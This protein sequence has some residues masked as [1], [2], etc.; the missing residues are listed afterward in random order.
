MHLFLYLSNFFNVR[1]KQ[2]QV[3]AYTGV[4]IS[5]LLFVDIHDLSQLSL[6]WEK[7]SMDPMR[8]SEEPSGVS[9]PFLE[10]LL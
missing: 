5:P 4:S 3:D 2:R 8:G 9:G 10:L 7:D 6:D 1:L